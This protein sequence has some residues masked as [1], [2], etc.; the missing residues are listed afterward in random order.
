MQLNIQKVQETL[1]RMGNDLEQA[2]S[3]KEELKTEVITVQDLLTKLNTSD[4]PLLKSQ[5]ENHESIL[6]EIKETVNKIQARIETVDDIKQLIANFSSELETL[7]KN[8]LQLEIADH[9]YAQNSKTL[10]AL[11]PLVLTSLTSVLNPI[12]VSY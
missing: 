10:L 1:K 12:C 5:L 6:G 8:V 4:I 2:K 7:Q 3:E 9:E 11:S